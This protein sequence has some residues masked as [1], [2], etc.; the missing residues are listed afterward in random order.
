MQIFGV[1]LLILSFLNAAV[2]QEGMPLDKS[3]TNRAE[4]EVA[5]AEQNAITSKVSYGEATLHEMVGKVD[6]ALQAAEDSYE[7]ARNTV[8]E[9]KASAT[10][11]RVHA[12][13]TDTARKD[14]QSV[15]P[16]MKGIAPAAAK[17]AAAWIMAQLKKE[18]IAEAEKRGNDDAANWAARKDNMKANALAGAAMPYHLAMM[19]AQKASAEYKHRADSA[20]AG[21]KKLVAAAQQA[22]AT[23]QVLQAGGHFIEVREYMANA[24]A[25]MNDAVKMQGWAA[26]FQAI[27]GKVGGSVTNGA[28][29]FSEQMGMAAGNL[30]AIWGN[31]N[32]MPLP[33][34][35]LQKDSKDSF[36][37]GSSSGAST[38]S[39]RKEIKQHPATTEHESMKSL[40]ALRDNSDKLT[41]AVHSLTKQ[42]DEFGNNAF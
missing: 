5:M 21:A 30:N 29:G 19:G 31:D 35:L 39:F 12:Y 40:K 38:S 4:H 15:V 24:H 27:A 33:G 17:A 32:P 14:A 26:K 1:P 20:I 42:I 10:R 18:A 8:P 16:E 23:A 41:K 2:C 28:I 37:K 34:A 25:M 36:A 6:D 13:N 22:A 9:S 3:V 11:A 7:L